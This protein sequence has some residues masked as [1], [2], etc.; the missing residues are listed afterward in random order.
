MF[1]IEDEFW[2]SIGISWLSEEQKK[3]FNRMV[4]EELEERVGGFLSNLLSEEQSEEFVG[5]IEG[6][7]QANMSWLR[8]NHPNYRVRSEFKYLK[9]IKGL[10]GDDLINRLASTLWLE[11]NVPNYREIVMNCEQ[12]LSQEIISAVRPRSTR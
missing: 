2:E 1:V 4:T 5:L 12:S 11:S 3:E 6:D 7:A 8:N 9:E 10:T